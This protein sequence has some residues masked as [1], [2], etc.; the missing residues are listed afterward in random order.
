MEITPEVQKQLDE[1]KKE[2]IFCKLIKGEIP[3]SQVYEDK[4]MLGVLDINPIVEGH[5]LL[6]PKE[7]YPIMPYIPEKTF[8]HMFGML[9]KILD[10]Y[11]K[12]L[13]SIEA[14]VFIANGGVAGQQSNHFMM[15]ILPRNGKDKLG[16]KFSFGN[17]AIVFLNK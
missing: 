8:F 5:T 12:K 4:F 14:N 13:Y 2:C 9:P 16:N 7:H 1:Q 17:F 6:M 15:H 10:V 11:C 3:S